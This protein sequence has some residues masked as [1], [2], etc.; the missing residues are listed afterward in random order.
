MQSWAEEASPPEGDHWQCAHH[1]LLL[2]V[3]A[4]PALRLS[5]GWI[6]PLGGPHGL[7]GLV[8]KACKPDLHMLT[9]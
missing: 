4:D 1:L 2:T 6:G 8:Q 9:D 3:G 7:P 5:E